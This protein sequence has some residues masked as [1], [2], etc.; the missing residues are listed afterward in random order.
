LAIAWNLGAFRWTQQLRVDYAN[1]L[2]VVLLAVDRAA[3]R[4]KCDDGPEEWTP[5]DKRYR[6][7]YDE[8]F[9]TILA[10]AT[11]TRPPLTRPP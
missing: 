5:P 4:A 3:N 7:S 6:C 2:A 11:S 1:D 10:T 9:A 8:R